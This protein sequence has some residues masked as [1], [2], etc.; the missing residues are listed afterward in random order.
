M[1]IKMFLILILAAFL[2]FGCVHVR[3]KALDL[4]KS[5]IKNAEATVQVA[6]NLLESW[7]VWSGAMRAGMQTSYYDLPGKA[8]LAWSQLDAISCR[9][10][11]DK[12]PADLQDLYDCKELPPLTWYEFGFSMGDR[13]LLLTEIVL[14]AVKTLVPDLLKKIPFPIAL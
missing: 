4:S 8:L 5:D 1:K 14:D 6:Q 9:Q 10:C 12:W 13:V 11:P 7:P 3:D 2:L